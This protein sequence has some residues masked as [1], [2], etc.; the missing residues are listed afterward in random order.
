MK[1]IAYQEFGGTAVLQTI[2]EPM[3]TIQA[4]QVLVKIKAVSINPLDWKLRKGEMKLMSGSKFPKHTGTDFAGIIDAVGASVTNVKKGDEVFGTVKNNMKEG[5][6]GEYAAVPS[7]LVWKKPAAINFVQAASIPTVGAAALMALQKI[8]KT[9]AQS[10]VLIN[11]AAGGFG[12]FLLQLLRLDGVNITAVADTHA[13]SFVKQWGADSVVDYSKENV[14]TKGDTYDA[15]VDLSG[16]MGYENARKIMK[17]KSV[18]IN[19]IPSPVD[20]LTTPIKNLFRSKK[21]IVLLSTPD[22]ET[23]D[24]LVKAIDNGLEIEVSKVFPF[25]Q[26]KEAYAYAEKGGYVGKVAIE[27][28]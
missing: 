24:R 17:A 12:M 19:P 7:T 21:Q 9:T 16:K 27:V 26:S 23:I 13:L 4:D 14:L 11:G 5:V 3:P 6:L 8:G 18:F 20:I 28:N 25:A 1:T 10:R 22:K 15:I 2:D